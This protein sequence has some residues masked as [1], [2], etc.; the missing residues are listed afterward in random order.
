MTASVS[1]AAIPDRSYRCPATFTA[2]RD[3]REAVRSFLKPYGQ[4]GALIL[5]DAGLIVSELVT[6]V[7]RAY[8][9]EPPG[10]GETRD[11]E[12]SLQVCGFTL[13]VEVTDWAPGIPDWHAEPDYIA[14][15][16][17]GLFTIRNLTADNCGTYWQ[18]DGSKR[19]WAALMFPR[20][21]VQVNET[22][23]TAPCTASSGQARG[24]RR[25]LRCA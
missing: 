23:N 16:G 10:H 11:F 13:L 12:L 25:G 2:P 19:V 20:D 6:N 1:T 15:T 21:E 4:R 3:A 17:R 7:V 5:D 9:T 22:A 18:A 8:G 14:E 24:T